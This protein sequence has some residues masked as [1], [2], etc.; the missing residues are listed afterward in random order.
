[1]CNR[2]EQILTS[3][4]ADESLPNQATVFALAP[5]TMRYDKPSDIACKMF[6]ASSAAQETSGNTFT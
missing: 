4:N 2:A 5:R 6:S 1:M 3:S